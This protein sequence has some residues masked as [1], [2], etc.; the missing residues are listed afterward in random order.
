MHQT[1]HSDAEGEMDRT[2]Q[3]TATIHC[4]DS[5]WILRS[6]VNLETM[7]RGLRGSASWMCK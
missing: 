6:A 2:I 1:L 4:R 3:I 7:K 5:V